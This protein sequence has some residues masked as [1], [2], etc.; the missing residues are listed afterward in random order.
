MGAGY[1]KSLDLRGTIRKR[2]PQGLL[3]SELPSLRA[4]KLWT[5]D[6]IRQK[7]W[8]EIFRR[9]QAVLQRKSSG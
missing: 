5:L 1:W 4:F 7:D 8:M 2:Y 3:N 9:K 6:P